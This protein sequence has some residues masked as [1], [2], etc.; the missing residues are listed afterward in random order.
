MVLITT[1]QKHQEIQSQS[2]LTS[3]AVLIARLDAVRI[4]CSLIAVVS[5]ANMVSLGA[6]NMRAAVLRVTAQL[7]AYMEEPM[8]QLVH[9]HGH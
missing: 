4:C 5:A 6:A 3:S 8:K 7:L 2:L 9:V 1:G